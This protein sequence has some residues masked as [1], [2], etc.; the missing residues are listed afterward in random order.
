MN[1]TDT[2]TSLVDRIRSIRKGRNL[3]QAK[4]AEKLGVTQSIV[5]LIESQ[6]SSVSINFLVKM[7]DHFDVSL[8]WLVHGTNVYERYGSSDMMPMVEG[9]AHADY[10]HKHKDKKFLQTLQLYKIP[11]FEKGSFRVFEVKGDSMIPTISDEDKLVVSEVSDHEHIVEGKIYVLV[12]KKDIVVKRLY[13]KPSSNG[14]KDT[15]ILRSDNTAYEEMEINPETVMEIWKV[16]AKIT[17]SFLQQ[18]NTLNNRISDLEDKIYQ[19]KKHLE[20][21]LKKDN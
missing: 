21:F 20:K 14:D 15:Y 1:L 12:L 11:G 10:I 8:D 6:K 7:S 5:S 4:L 13:F 19:M 3:T 9:A 17:S 18:N 2:N 16:E